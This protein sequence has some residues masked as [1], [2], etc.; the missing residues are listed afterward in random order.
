MYERHNFCREGPIGVDP[1]LSANQPVCPGMRMLEASYPVRP[2]SQFFKVAVKACCIKLLGAPCLWGL[3]AS[4]LG[5]CGYEF[6]QLIVNSVRGF[7]K[8]ASKGIRRQGI[9][10]KPRSSLLP[11]RRTPLLMYVA[12]RLPE[13]R[14]HPA[15]ALTAAPAAA[16]AAP[17]GPVQGELK[18]QTYKPSNQINKQHIKQ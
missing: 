8:S 4:L 9:V 12:L 15:A 2:S 14:Q 6:D 5:A 11:C 18:Q 13:E 17:A 10:L 3:A 7:P 1:I 16:A